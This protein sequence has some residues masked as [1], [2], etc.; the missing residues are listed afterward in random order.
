[1][2]SP[3]TI[4]ICG[5]TGTQGSAMITN[6]QSS[7]PTK[8][9]I[10]SITRD[11]STPRSKALQAAGVTMFKGDFND[12]PSIRNALA[13]CTALFLNLS[14]NLGD[15]TQEPS[16]AKR[17]ISVAKDLG[18]N[19]IVYSSALV[20]NPNHC[21]YWDAS[22]LAG[23]IVLAKNEVEDIVR[24]AGIRYTILRPGNF[25]TNFL[26]PVVGFQYPGLVENGKFTTA[27]TRD[28]VIP[29]VDPRDIG[30]FGAA[31]LLDPERYN[32]KDI[33]IASELVTLD[34]ILG[35]LS[36][37]TGRE[38]KADYLGQEEIDA[39]VKSNPFVGAQLMMRDVVDEV[40]V[41]YMKSFGIEMGSF[42]EFLE[43]EEKWVKETFVRA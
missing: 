25:M 3:S 21:K 36:Q 12:E 16:Q 10:H 23:N 28:T 39:Q 15:L 4:F 32:G 40:D 7:H 9:K 20:T 14:P 41:E 31:A 24:S 1:M 13:G 33:A 17:I 2:S 34:G 11:L 18:I 30:K 27:F 43:R 8:V 26:A 5:A 35:S 37:V 6:L 19:H 22:S 29:M 42:A 38:L